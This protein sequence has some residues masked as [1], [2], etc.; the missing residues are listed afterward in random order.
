VGVRSVQRISPFSPNHASYP[1]IGVNI[2]I[3]RKRPS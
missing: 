2:V 3:A 1:L